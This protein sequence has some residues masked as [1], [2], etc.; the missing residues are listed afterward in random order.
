MDNLKLIIISITIAIIIFIT[1]K[2]KQ[3]ECNS[4][5]SI[6]EKVNFGGKNCPKK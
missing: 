4:P 2:Q 3:I 6:A 1:Q 5:N